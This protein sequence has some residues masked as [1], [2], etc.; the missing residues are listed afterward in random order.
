VRQSTIDSI[1]KKI[2]P[3]AKKTL[4]TIESKLKNKKTL[5]KS[6]KQF[7][8]NIENNISKIKDKENLTQELIQAFNRAVSE[9]KPALPEKV[10]I[11][12]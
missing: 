5:Q 7:L 11:E 3:E 6:E 2:T 10:T 12:R 8:E 1:L 9:R 4:Q